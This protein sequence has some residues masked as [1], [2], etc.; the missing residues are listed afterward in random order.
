MG[1]DQAHH[2]RVVKNICPAIRL[3]SHPCSFTDHLPLRELIICSLPLIPYFFIFLYMYLFLAALCL[4]CCAWAFSRCREQGL[5]FIAVRGLLIVVASHCGAWAVGAWAQQLWLTGCRAQAQ[6][7]QHTGL[8][9]LWHVGSSR[10]RARTHVPCIGR[11]I[12][13]HCA[14]REVPPYL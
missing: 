3:V 13:N 6:Q 9:A 4:R 12:L 10:T 11:W 5:L 1:S 7:L 8:V 14:T 2:C